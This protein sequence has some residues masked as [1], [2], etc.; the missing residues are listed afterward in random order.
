MQRWLNFISV[1]LILEKMPDE[2]IHFPA[3]GIF[4]HNGGRVGLDRGTKMKDCAGRMYSATMG[5]P[6]AF[7]LFPLQEGEIGLSEGLMLR[8][9][10]KADQ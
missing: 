1:S 10:G 4:W 9:Q 7:I 2:F 8:D 5:K 3:F 6:V